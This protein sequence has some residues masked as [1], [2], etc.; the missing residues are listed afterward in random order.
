MRRRCIRAKRAPGGAAVAP[1]KPNGPAV[2]IESGFED[3]PS[4]DNVE[5]RRGIQ[6]AALLEAWPPEYRGGGF[7]LDGDDLVI[8]APG[9]P[10]LR[11]ENAL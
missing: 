5:S 1:R 11:L 8:F 6:S 7:R 4:Q 10:D 9:K 2:T 3:R